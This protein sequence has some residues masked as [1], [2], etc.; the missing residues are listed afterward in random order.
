MLDKSERKHEVA[1]RTNAQNLNSSRTNGNYKSGDYLT[2]HV[3][4]MISNELSLS[5][6]CRAMQYDKYT[7]L[8]Y[9][10]ED[11]A[12][13]RNKLPPRF[14]RSRYLK[15]IQDNY[16]SCSC[17]C[18]TRNKIPYRHILSVVRE[19]SPFMFG[20]RWFNIFQY[21]FEMKG[22]GSLSTV[23]RHIENDEFSRSNSIGNSIKN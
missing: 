11:K 9:T 6:L 3:Y 2:N 20:I 21:A 16:L 22:F 14:F 19:Y 1:H 23:F 18:A 5:K 13:E 8:V 17:C 10:P 4:K 7:F 15:F 12:I